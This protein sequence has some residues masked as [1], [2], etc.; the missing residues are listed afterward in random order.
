MSFDAEK[1][2][3]TANQ[4]ADAILHIEHQGCV[5]QTAETLGQNYPHLVDLMERLA[6]RLAS[7]T[8]AWQEEMPFTG[9]RGRQELFCRGTPLL[10]SEGQWQG[11]VVVFDDVT[12]LIQA[13]RSAA[14]GEVARRLAH[15][16]RN[17]LTPI[18][19]SAER[20]QH[21]LAHSLAA[22]EADILER[23]TRTIVQQV[24]AMKFMVNAFAEYAKPAGT[25]L[26]PVDLSGLIEEVVSL[27]PSPSGIEF[28]LALS[29]DLPPIQGDPVKLRQVLHNLIK[30]AQEAIPQESPGR[31]TITTR[32]HEENRRQYILIQLQDN[33]PGISREHLDRIFEPYVTSKAK[34]TGLGLAIVKKIIEE[35]GGSIQLE[36]S[37]ESGAGFKIMLP[38]I[39]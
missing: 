35:H 30:N 13:Q 26:E 19:L 25:R 29:P 3:L 20:L 24:E 39:R 28:D 8:G 15:E 38:V 2:V 17:P 36:T 21:K 10:D 6:R 18:Q 16:I 12:A 23:A 14:W 9:P 31:M 33:G 4:S 7:E 5:G 1:R 37:Q 32:F 22:P 11:A 27:Y 34:G